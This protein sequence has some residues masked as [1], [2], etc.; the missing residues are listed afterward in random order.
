MQLF[1]VLFF[2]L[3]TCLYPGP[4]DGGRGGGGGGGHPVH[5]SGARRAR[6]GPHNL[7][8]NIFYFEKTYQ[9]F[10]DLFYFERA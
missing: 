9:K 8:K 2:N 5:R 10:K 4:M 6:K 3:I 7:K 1:Y